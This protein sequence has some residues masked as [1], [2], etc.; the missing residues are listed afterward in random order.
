MGEVG[1][2]RKEEREVKEACVRVHMFWMM[3]ERGVSK[4]GGRGAHNLSTKWVIKLINELLHA[5]VGR[6]R[7]P[8]VGN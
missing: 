5:H 7:E 6:G 1:E 8:K 2:V 4:K 3:E